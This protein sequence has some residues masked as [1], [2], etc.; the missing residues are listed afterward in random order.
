M[1]TTSPADIITL[2]VVGDIEGVRALAVVL[3]TVELLL[4]RGADVRQRSRIGV[5]AM[6]TA[7]ANGDLRVVRRLIAAGDAPHLVSLDYGGPY[8]NQTPADIARDRGQT[9]VVEYLTALPA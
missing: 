4:G 8:A 3:D 5:T 2:A 1:T 6:F 7:A 9:N